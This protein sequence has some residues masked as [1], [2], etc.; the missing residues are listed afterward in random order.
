RPSPGRTAPRLV[1]PGQPPTDILRAI[2]SGR[3]VCMRI[4]L[5]LVALTSAVF[6]QTPTGAILGTVRDGSGLA[7]PGAAVEI[8]N[9]ETGQRPATRPLRTAWG[10]PQFRISGATP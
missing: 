10:D 3:E 6:G 5:L 2:T 9:E 4:G 1:E 8:R 7:V